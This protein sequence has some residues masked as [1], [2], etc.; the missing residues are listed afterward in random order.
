[1]QQPKPEPLGDQPTPTPSG[2]KQPTPKL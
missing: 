2:M 1:M